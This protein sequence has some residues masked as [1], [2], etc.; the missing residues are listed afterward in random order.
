MPRYSKS[1]DHRR[2]VEIADLHDAATDAYEERRAIW[3]RRL[4]AGDSQAELARLSRVGRGDIVP[5]VRRAK[6]S[7]KPLDGGAE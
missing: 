1:R 6:K 5:G 3:R 7:A 2:L 4:E